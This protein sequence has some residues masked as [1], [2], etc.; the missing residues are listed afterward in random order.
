MEGVSVR[1]RIFVREQDFT[2][3][4]KQCTFVFMVKVRCNQ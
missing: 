1:Q 2:K 4:L 3:I